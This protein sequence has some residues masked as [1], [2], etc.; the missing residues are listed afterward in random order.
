MDGPRVA[1]RGGG[2][3]QGR[4]RH[5]EDA[6]PRAGQHHAG[7]AVAQPPA[8]D[9]A[10]E[11][12]ESED[13]QDQTELV[14]HPGLADDRAQV[15]YARVAG[16]E[17]RD[18]DGERE[19][20]LPVR[21]AHEQ[22]ADRGNTLRGGGLARPDAHEDRDEDGD[23]ASAHCPEH[24]SVP[25]APAHEGSERHGDDGRQRHARGDH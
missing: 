19:D 4:Q 6:H 20:G 14:A 17:D 8:E 9:A 21:Q 1:V 5:G 15:R 13:Q 22:C 16:D 25:V 12:T 10:Q 2:Q 3:A 23:G 18:R 7:P 11:R 24:R